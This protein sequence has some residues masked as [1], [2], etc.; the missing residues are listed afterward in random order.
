MADKSNLLKLPKGFKDFMLA[1]AYQK[2]ALE[3]KWVQLFQSW[4]YNEIVSSS[5]EYYDTLIMNVG[6]NPLNLLKTID[7][8]GHI[9]A[10][11][12]DMTSP[13]A[14]LVAT[15]MKD[16]LLPQRLFYLANVFRYET[17]VRKGRH[18]EFHQAGVELIGPKGAR[19]DGEVIAL[20]IKAL[21]QAGLSDFQIGLGHVGLTKL[22]LEHLANEASHMSD[23]KD[24]LGRKDFVELANLLQLDNHPQKKSIF[25]VVTQQAKL[26]SMLDKLEGLID[27]QRFLMAI[28]DLKVFGETLEQ[29]K[30]ADRVFIDFS[31]LRDFDYYTGIVFEG[32]SGNLGYPICAGGRYDRLLGTFG[33]D[34]PAT[35]FA[36]GLERVLVALSKEGKFVKPSAGYFVSGINQAEV[37]SKAEALRRDGYVVE[38]DMMG[39]SPGE[40]KEYARAK[41]INNLV[42]V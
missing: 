16:Q 14:R 7:R 12:P 23:I 5:F 6:I 26:W 21:E 13:I 29:Y 4:S 11:R 25:N 30:V 10:L 9:L 41:G 3:N 31:I 27:D 18:M 37:L 17:V 32:Y 1:E 15:Q 42:V 39:L 38:V 28:Q 24:A 34:C 36:L 2:R 8:T 22:L 35:G 40:A 33:F 20:A 19:A